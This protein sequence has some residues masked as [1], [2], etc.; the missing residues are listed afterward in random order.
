LLLSY[1]TNWGAI[2]FAV[3]NTEFVDFSGGN[4]VKVR[5]L[6]T[7]ATVTLLSLGVAAGCANPCAAKEKESGTTTETTDEAADPCASKEAADPC[8]AKDEA[9]DPCAAKDEAADPCASKETADPC[10]AK[11]EAADPCAAKD[12]AADPCA[13]KNA[14]DAS[15]TEEAGE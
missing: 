7:L 9:A 1:A 6:T 15:E 12:E 5:Y 8:A 10:A 13:A 4:A 14:D 3:S 11:D 2:L